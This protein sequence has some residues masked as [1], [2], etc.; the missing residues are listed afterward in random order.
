MSSK[1]CYPVF[2]QGDT[3]SIGID[4]LQLLLL[5]NA[6]LLGVDFQLGM[7]YED[8]E[9]V[10]DPTTQMLGETACFSFAVSVAMP[11]SRAIPFVPFA[12]QGSLSGRCG[13]LVMQLQ[14]SSRT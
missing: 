6:L 5:K 10:L 3:S 1:M 11:Q 4:E 8:A 7:S 14:Q 13:S 2:T 9:I 12:V